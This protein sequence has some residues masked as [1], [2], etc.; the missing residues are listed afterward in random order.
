MADLVFLFKYAFLEN[1][2][3][4]ILMFLVKQPVFN[5]DVK[6]L[7]IHL[8]RLVCFRLLSINFVLIVKYFPIFGKPFFKLATKILRLNFP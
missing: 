6:G 3:P 1:S 2:S 5:I 4:P 7:W 8:I